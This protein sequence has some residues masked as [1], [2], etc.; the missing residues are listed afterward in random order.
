LRLV[1][2]EKINSLAVVGDAMARPLADE[3]RRGSHDLS[4]LAVVGSGGAV[5]SDAVK[6]ELRAQLPSLVII[7]TFGSSE[8]GA[9]GSSAPGGKG[10]RF[11]PGE[12]TAVLDEMTLQP[13]EPGSGAVGKLA[14]RGHIPLGYWKDAAKTE[15][16]FPTVDGVRWAVPGDHATVEPDGTVVLLGRGSQCI[17][18]GGEKVFPEEVEAALKAHPSVYDA[19]VVGVPDE[20]WV[21]KVVA[22]VSPRPG[23]TPELAELAAHCRTLVAGYKVPRQLIVADEVRRTVVGKPDL[24]WAKQFALDRLS[25]A[26]TD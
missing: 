12:E 7:D 6:D 1:E 20:R 16:T 14:R 3:M 10:A 19:V 4:T 11:S 26:S 17:N 21:E 8:I 25:A 24:K 23:T 15:A 22:I 18:T 9:A 5:L 2:K 13:I